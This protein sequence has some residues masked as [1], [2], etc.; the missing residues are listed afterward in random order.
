MADRKVLIGDI[1]DGIVLHHQDQ[2]TPGSDR[3][4]DPDGR[5]LALLSEIPEPGEPG[6]IGTLGEVRTIYVDAERTDEY[7]PDGSFGKPFIEMQDALDALMTLVA[8]TVGSEVN[9]AIRIAPSRKYTSQA[10]P[11]V[12]TLPSS[13]ANARRL[14]LVADSVGASNV[15]LLPPMRV[16]SPSNSSINFIAMRG[17]SFVGKNGGSGDTN[18]VMH[19]QGH[20]SFTGQ[21]RFYLSDVQFTTS[22]NADNAFYVDAGGGSFG[23]FAVGHCTFS[24]NSADDGNAIYMERGWL[25]LRNSNIWGGA[26]PA[27]NLS[28]SAS[29]TLMSGELT[30][31]AGTDTPLVTLADTASVNLRDVFATARGTGAVVSHSGAGGFISL[32]DVQV[33]PTSTGGI[34]ALSGAPI[35]LGIC[36]RPTGVPVPVNVASPAQIIRLIPGAQVA[37]ADESSDGDEGSAWAT[38]APLTIKD[39]IDRL[40]T[41]VAAHLGG[42]IPE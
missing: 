31:T 37:Y 42:T 14:A 5:T 32:Y 29:V 35:L 34:E 2:W 18:S 15:I 17:L 6:E 4:I 36:V 41:Q 16:E 38:S 27:I 10:S 19:V 11:L 28:G 23:M 9:A 24:V 13:G 26:A 20:A 3:L 33:D 12:M 40:A 8:D 25:N 21:I 22:T 7:T 39:A 30:V 1:A